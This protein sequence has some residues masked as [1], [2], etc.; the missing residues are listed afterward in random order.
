V[1]RGC[2]WLGGDRP[3]AR[4]GTTSASRGGRRCPCPISSA[5]LDD[6]AEMRTRLCVEDERQRLI[7]RPSLLEVPLD[8]DGNGR[9]SAMI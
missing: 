6:V 1:L 2:P 9:T 8:R 7:S 3:E 5:S 4:D